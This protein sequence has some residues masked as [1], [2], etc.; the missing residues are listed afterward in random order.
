MMPNL[1][2]FLRNLMI[3]LLV[4]LAVGLTVKYLL[5]EFILWS[6]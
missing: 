2:Q 3:A 4:G 1:D 5:V 6:R